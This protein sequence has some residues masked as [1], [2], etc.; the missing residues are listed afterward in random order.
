MIKKKKEKKDFTTSA[1]IISWKALGL[2]KV[3]CMRE[4][5]TPQAVFNLCGILWCSLKAHFGTWVFKWKWFC[6]TVLLGDYRFFYKKYILHCLFG[7]CAFRNCEEYE[8][9]KGK[10]FMKINWFKQGADKCVCA[11]V[12]VWK[13]LWCVMSVSCVGAYRGDNWLLSYWLLDEIL[14]L[15]VELALG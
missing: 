11:R 6:Q 1:F 2:L 8:P 10:W 13:F 9:E 15:D 14:A 4:V 12:Y 7:C 3:C 5:Q